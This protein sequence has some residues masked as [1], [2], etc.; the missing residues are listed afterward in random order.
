MACLL[1]E[2]GENQQSP[3]IAAHRAAAQSQLML[4]TRGGHDG[5]SSS[6]HVTAA[7]DSPRGTTP[8]PP[9]AAAAAAPAATASANTG[10]AGNGSGGSVTKPAASTVNTDLTCSARLVNA[11]SHP[12]TVET[13]RPRRSAIT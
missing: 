12:R 4:A 8:T 3:R 6:P 5:A 11:R 13:G 2:N 7:A 10:P 1:S 9:P